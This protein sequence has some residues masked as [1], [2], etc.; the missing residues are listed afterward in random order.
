MVPKL[1]G[2]GIVSRCQRSAKRSTQDTGVLRPTWRLTGMTMTVS[3]PGHVEEAPEEE[4]EV[5][6]VATHR[7]KRV[8]VLVWRRKYVLRGREGLLCPR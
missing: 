1:V 6:M 4:Q 2:L 7:V 5:L 8:V 3:A